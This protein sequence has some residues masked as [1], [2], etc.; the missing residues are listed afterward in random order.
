MTRMRI[1]TATIEKILQ[2]DAIEG[3]DCSEIED[4]LEI[5]EHDSNS[6]QSSEEESANFISLDPVPIPEDLFQRRTDLNDVPLIYIRQGYYLSKNGA[7]K[8]SIEEPPRSVRTRRH[9]IIRELPGP[10]N[11]AKDALTPLDCWALMFPDNVIEQIVVYT[12]TYIAAIQN[13]FQR[14]RDCLPTGLIEL[15]GLLG[16]LYY[17]GKLRGAH[18]NT[19]DYWATDG[20]GSDIAIAT[21]S[22]QRFHFLL[23]CLRFD[24]ISTREQRRQSDKLA[25]IRDYFTTFVGTIKKYYSL[26]DTVTIDEKLEPF[27]GRC[28]FRQ[29]MPN[30]PAR[31]GIKIFVM[32]DSRTY[33]T[34][35]ME[36]YAGKQ[37]AG[38]YDVSNSPLDLV[39]RMV[40]HIKGSNRNVVMDNWFNSFPLITELYENYGLTVLGTLRKNKPE[41]PSVFISTKGREEKSTYFGFQPNCTLLSYAP[42]KGKVVLLVSTMHHDAMIDPD[43]GDKLKPTMITD[44]NMH[45]CGVDVVDEMCGT[46]SVSRVSKRWPLTIF[47]GLMNVGAINAYVIYNANM[48]RLQKETVERRQFLKDIALGLVLPQIQNRSS[49][50]TLPKLIRTK[51]SQILGKEEITDRSQLTGPSSAVRGRCSLCPT[52]KDR[53]TKTWCHLCKTFICRDHTIFVCKNC[54]QKD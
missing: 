14:E 41:I 30:K 28:P 50:T 39:K 9:N 38:P 43:T 37:N 16:L 48:K 34:A 2:E 4:I 17:F 46:Y 21:M 11:E 12:N 18:L 53:K 49:I 42:K 54:E 25:A 32:A 45:K 26:G 3:E 36:I 35:E 24:D 44:Y 52:K 15:K 47:F 51:M 27:R 5:D 10:I 6:S 40:E 1:D 22:R 29:Y 8:W 13:K 33:Y 23:R 7:I 19:K 20:T 31:Y